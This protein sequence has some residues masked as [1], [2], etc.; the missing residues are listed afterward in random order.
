MKRRL[1]VSSLA[2][3][4]GLPARSSAGDALPIFSWEEPHMGTLW[5]I[6]VPAA[7]REAAEPAVRKAFARIAEL[8]A[9]L[10]D[11]L[12]DSELSRLS[13]TAGSGRPVA[14]S[15]DLWNVLFFAQQ[16]S[17][18]CAGLFDVTLGPC[19]ALWRRSRRQQKLPE[20]DKLQAARA[21]SSWKFLG[22]DDAKRT[23]LLV[24]PG[25]K[26]DAGGIAKGYAQD[27]AF[28]VLTSHGISS[29]LINAGGEAGTSAPPPGRPAWSVELTPAVPS[30]GPP[31]VAAVSDA[32]VAT[33]GDLH[34]FTEIN[35]ARYSHIIDPATGLGMHERAHAIVI[36]PSG[37][38]AD[39]VATVLCL[40]GPDQSLPWL[41]QHHP[42]I[43]ARIT[44]IPTASHQ[45]HSRQTKGFARY[46]SSYREP[47]GK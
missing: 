11:Y 23:A 9:C 22:L 14:V 18:T 44:R 40:L 26:L 28:R 29:A 13:A 12:P 35:G 45:P 19:T 15:N 34:Q 36:A 38:R 5:T 16:A 21:A 39:V 41:A 31:E 42:D 7:S 10:S 17:A 27:E 1:F 32:F 4:A 6:K 2:A 24:R 30:E 8:N 25:M 33:S 3:A 43:E 37:M 46:L 20:P 47:K